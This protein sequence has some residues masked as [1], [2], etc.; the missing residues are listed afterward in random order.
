[1]E[2]KPI[3][4]RLR[5]MQDKGIS[6]IDALKILYL[7]KYPIF[8]ITSYIGITSSELQK[9]NEQIK[10]FLLR[11]P[12]GHR[13]LDDP[14]LHAEDAHYCVECKRWFNETTLR[15]E[16]ELEIKRL[17]EIESNVA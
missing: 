14:A 9:L 11:C 1:M 16:I 12:A 5:E 3:A 6:R 8:E 4:E 15:D 10:L 7:E 13:F 2:R 17:R